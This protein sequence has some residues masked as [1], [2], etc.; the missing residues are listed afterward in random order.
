MK[1]LTLVTIVFLAAPLWASTETQITDSVAQAQVSEQLRSQ[2][3][4]SD[5]TVDLSLQLSSVKERLLVDPDTRS[6]SFGNSRVDL[7]PKSWPYPMVVSPG[8]PVL[9][10][11]AW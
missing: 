9:P 7:A 6:D 11:S 1:V 4:Q 5:R 8:R 3:P 10:G 2:I